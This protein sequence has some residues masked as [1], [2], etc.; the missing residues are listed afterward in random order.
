MTQ[1]QEAFCLA[2]IELGDAAKAYRSAY[3]TERMKPETIWKRSS[4][5]M[6]NGEVA[7][8]IEELRHAAA[9]SATL[10]LEGHLST[11]A[12]LR[13]KAE[14]LEQMS[15]AINAEV[16]RGKAAGFYVQKQEITGKDGG[17][18]ELSAPKMDLAKLTNEEFEHLVEL[19][20]KATYTE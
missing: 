18:L 16:A 5:L 20:E 14:S 8:R 7:G 1:K 10:T 6:T 19:S 12:E 13:D 15:A 4:E 11:L 9:E 2:Y 17:P 3:R